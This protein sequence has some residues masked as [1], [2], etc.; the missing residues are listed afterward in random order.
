VAYNKGEVYEKLD[1]LKKKKTPIHVILHT[2]NT[3]MQRKKAVTHRT[4]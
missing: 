4:P 2:M 3:T 1:F